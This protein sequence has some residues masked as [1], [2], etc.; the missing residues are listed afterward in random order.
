[1]SKLKRTLSLRS[2]RRSYN[3][4][5]KVTNGTIS[6]TSKITTINEDLNPTQSSRSSRASLRGIKVSSK[7]TD[8]GE[9]S[10]MH[11]SVSTVAHH[12]SQDENVKPGSSGKFPSLDRVRSALV[13]I[14][15]VSVSVQY[16]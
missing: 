3:A 10:T 15:Q 9:I 16:H 12:S 14:G 8:S 13:T 2:R 5:P 7:Q 6:P 4:L 1:M 11:R